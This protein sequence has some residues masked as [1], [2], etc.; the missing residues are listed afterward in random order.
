[1]KWYNPSYI[2]DVAPAI[3][4]FSDVQ[5]PKKIAGT[6]MDAHKIITVRGSKVCQ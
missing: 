3:Q 2:F 4:F 1:M 5:L 6:L